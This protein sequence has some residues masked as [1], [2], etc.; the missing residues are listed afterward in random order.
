MRRNLCVCHEP[1]DTLRLPIL[2]PRIL[3]ETAHRIGKFIMIRKKH[4]LWNETFL[5]AYPWTPMVETVP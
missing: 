2:A 3:V 5:A 1:I 4:I